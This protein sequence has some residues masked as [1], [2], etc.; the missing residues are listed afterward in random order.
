[1]PTSTAPEPYRP[2]GDPDGS[3]PPVVTLENRA[4]RLLRAPL[5]LPIVAFTLIVLHVLAGAEQYN[6]SAR[7]LSAGVGILA[8]LVVRTVR[9]DRLPFMALA[10]VQVYIFFG[11]ASCWE[12]DLLGSGGPIYLHPGSLVKA[13]IAGCV[14]LCAAYLASLGGEA[15]GR[16]LRP[17]SDRLL[18]SRVDHRFAIPLRLWS[19]VSIGCYFIILMDLQVGSGALDFAIRQLGNPFF[20]QA[21]LFAEWRT[22]RSKTSWVWFVGFTGAAAFA[23][24]MSGF[25]SRTLYPIITFAV[26]HWLAGRSSVYVLLAATLAFVILNPVKHAFREEIWESGEHHTSSANIGDRVDAWLTA[27][28]NSWGGEEEA[29]AENLRNASERLSGLLRVAQAIQW[30][31]YKVPY[32]G[33]APWAEIPLSYIPQVLR[34]EKQQLTETFNDT[35]ALTFGLQSDREV[36]VSTE[37][38]PPMA[39][40]FWVMGWLGVVL[41]AIL[42]GGLMGIYQG[43][44]DPSHGAAAAVGM[45]LIASIKAQSHLA[46][47][48]AGLPQ[49]I[50]VM[51]AILWALALAANAFGKSPPRP[52]R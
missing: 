24:L 28:E 4:L 10:A 29:T 23:G 31:P 36:A 40:G 14:F 5:A 2:T 27:F 50:L 20:V 13:A 43:I 32:R 49:K 44:F 21:L 19:F 26:L 25:L 41:I 42:M 15:L 18:P 38:L 39:E 7:L 6:L 48:Y 34:P 51:V 35:Y 11:L 46:Q 16:R 8:F 45:G 47:L 1:M 9:P 22:S 33:L 37:N 3:G 12:L 52:G 17:W 30:V